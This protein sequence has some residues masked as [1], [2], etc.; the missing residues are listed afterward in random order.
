MKAWWTLNC[1]FTK[2]SLTLVFGMHVVDGVIWHQNKL[3]PGAKEVIEWFQAND[4]QF[5]F[6]TNSS[7]M[8]QRELQQKLARMGLFVRFRAD[9]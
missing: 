5:L 2:M 6:L 9:H 3:I 7:Q 1:V 8:S 4:K